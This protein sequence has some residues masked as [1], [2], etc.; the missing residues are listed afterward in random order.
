MSE[1]LGCRQRTTSSVIGVP[2]DVL[3]WPSVLDSVAEM[4]QTGKGYY[5]CICNVHSVVTATQDRE[6][7]DVVR[8]ADLATPDGAPV[9]WL[10]R[11]LGVEGQARINGPDLMWKYLSEAATCGEPVYL[12]GGAQS[13]LDILTKVLPERMP[14]LVIAGAYSPP[15]RQL[16][17][18]EDEQIVEAINTS[19][20]KTV[21]VSLGCPKQELWMAEHRDR[22]NAVMIGVGAAFDYHAGV[23]KRA[24][25]WMQ[26]SG[27]E[28]LH[29]LSSEP[30]RLFKRYLSTNSWFIYY[31]VRQ[32]LKK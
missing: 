2:I 16:T 21:W 13:T 7:G 4:A 17:A 24:P 3:S 11:R 15:F 27:L 1:Q 9:A 29:R 18:Q 31:A 30:K 14:G 12:Y 26:H 25:L 10:M 5:V 6:F 19:G 32:L 28:W 22:V 23:I 20:A 8:N